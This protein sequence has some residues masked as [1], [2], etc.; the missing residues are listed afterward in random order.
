MN[1]LQI[2]QSGAHILKRNQK[3]EIKK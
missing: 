1:K 2:K 3:K